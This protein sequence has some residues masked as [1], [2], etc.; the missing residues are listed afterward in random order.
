VKPAA[1]DTF[2]DLYN[3]QAGRNIAAYA[4]QKNLSREQI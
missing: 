3:N 2:K 1:W 4:R